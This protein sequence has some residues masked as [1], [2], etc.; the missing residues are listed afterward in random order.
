MG[1]NGEHNA[2]VLEN[3]KIDL[4]SENKR[5]KYHHKYV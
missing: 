5:S 3:N 2:K 4:S 1:K